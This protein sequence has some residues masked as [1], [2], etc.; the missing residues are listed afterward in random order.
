M[1]PRCLHNRAQ[2]F[3][4]HTENWRRNLI[5]GVVPGLGGLSIIMCRTRTTTMGTC[6]RHTYAEDNEYGY[7]IKGL[8]VSSEKWNNL[9]QVT[10]WL[11]ALHKTCLRIL[12]GRLWRGELKL[13][14]AV[15]DTILM[16]NGRGHMRLSTLNLPT[17]QMIGCGTGYAHMGISTMH[18]M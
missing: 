11:L 9:I 12:A 5:Y 16:N 8:R 4:G 6:R 3:G 10:G 18:A 1:P 2:C 15:D 17:S 13:V 7:V 14:G